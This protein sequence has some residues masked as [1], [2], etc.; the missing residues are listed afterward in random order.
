M[1]EGP[2]GVLSGRE[3]EIK[4]RVDGKLFSQ[5]RS[6]VL[7]PKYYCEEGLVK[8][9]SLSAQSCFHCQLPLQRGLRKKTRVNRGHVA[10]SHYAA[11]K[12]YTYEDHVIMKKTYTTDYYMKSQYRNL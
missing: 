9:W 6:A 2:Y 12:N 5:S 11:A 3:K 8:L 7:S 4:R 10:I 1:A